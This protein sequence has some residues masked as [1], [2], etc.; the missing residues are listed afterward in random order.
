VGT[1]GWVKANL[2]NGWFNSLLTLV[3]LY[4]L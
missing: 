2:F 1:I 3:T 4:L